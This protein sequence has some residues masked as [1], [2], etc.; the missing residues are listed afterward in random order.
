MKMMMSVR[1]LPNKR[2]SIRG[3]PITRHITDSEVPTATPPHHP[4]HRGNQRR[5]ATLRGHKYPQ[6]NTATVRK[7]PG[8][9]PVPQGV[10]ITIAFPLCCVHT[11]THR[12]THT[13]THTHAH[14]H[15]NTC[16]HTHAYTHT[17]S[18]SH[19]H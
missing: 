13:H 18:H 1:T 14:A 3:Q 15:T 10:T 17:H 11:H 4:H 12:H 8:H 16:T 6:S 5:K 9:H 7:M 19:T 2:D